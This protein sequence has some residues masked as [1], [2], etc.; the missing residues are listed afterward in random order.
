MLVNMS[1]FDSYYSESILSWA[2]LSLH[3][4]SLNTILLI[5]LGHSFAI[6][7]LLTSQ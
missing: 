5:L 2:I 7:G 3:L 1:V 6:I 4:K